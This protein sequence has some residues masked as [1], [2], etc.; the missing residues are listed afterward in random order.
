[1]SYYSHN[2]GYDYT[3]NNLL[4][5]SQNNNFENAIKKEMRL[6]IQLIYIAGKLQKIYEREG[7][8]NNKQ[9]MTGKRCINHCLNGK[10]PH[11]Q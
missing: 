5:N 9:I 11:I 10:Y 7:K 3:T 1:M 6:I 2:I 4:K 8:G